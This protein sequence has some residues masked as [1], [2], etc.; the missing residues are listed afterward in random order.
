M[1]SFNILKKGKQTGK[2]VHNIT[3]Y[4]VTDGHYQEVTTKVVS[5][6]PDNKEN[7]ES[8]LVLC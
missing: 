2:M 1:G 8:S 5:L 6:L 7:I 4:F 3:V